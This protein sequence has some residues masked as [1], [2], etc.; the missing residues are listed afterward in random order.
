MTQPSAE[1]T[2]TVAIVDVPEHHRFEITV[3]GTLAG[4]TEYV[5]APADGSADGSAHGSADGSDQVVGQRTFPHTVIH[6][7]YGG[8]GLATLLIRTALDATRVADLAVIPQCPAVT[9]VI[10]KHPAYLGLVP[11]SRRDEFGL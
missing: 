8:R 10:A 6:D 3:E 1:P 11:A 9:H 2:E 7:E 5:D 4:F